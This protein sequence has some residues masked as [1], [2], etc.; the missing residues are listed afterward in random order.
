M[1]KNFSYDQLQNK[2]EAL[3]EELA[4]LRKSRQTLVK[5]E[6]LLRNIADNSLAG[7][8]VVQN[9]K[10][11][12][13]NTNATSF[14]GYGPEELIGRS[15]Y[16]IVHTEDRAMVKQNARAMLRGERKS[17]YEFRIIS[18]NKRVRWILEMVTAI[19]YKG[20]PAILGNSMDITERKLK[21][22]VLRESEQRLTDIIAFLPDATLAIDNEG[23]VIIWNR[24]IEEMT[25]IPAKNML[26]KGNYEYALPFYRERRPLLVD[27]LLKPDTQSEMKYSIV[28]KQQDLLIAEAESPFLRGKCAFLWGKASPLYDSRGNILGAIET[29]RDITDRKLAEEGLRESERRLSD[30]I[31]F[32]PD[33][34]LVIDRK[35]KVIAWNRAIEEMTGVTAQDMLGKENHEYAVPFYGKPRPIMI[36]LVLKSNSKVERGYCSII[37]RQ[38]DLLIVETW[39]PALKGKRAFLWG[40]ASPLYDSKRNVVGAIES[41]RDITERKQDEE[42]LKNREQELQAKKNQLE[43]LNAALRVLLK[44]REE[45]KNDL[46]EKILANVKKLIIPYLDKL[47]MESKGLKTMAYIGVLESNLKDIIAPFAHRISSKYVSLTNREVQIAGLIKEG[48][49]TKEIAEMLNISESAI[50]IHRYNIRRKLGLTKKHNLQTYLSSLA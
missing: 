8:Y 19:T 24:A 33:A 29:I 37:E 2:L 42:A 17:P 1:S 6:Q 18:K 9:G 38:Q 48:R 25:G 15:S 49:I 35:G 34:T 50:N 13:L 26:G 22:D 32:L 41:I 4:D 27:L 46:E 10:F 16:Y 11:R 3:E 30:I 45:D 5:G 39:V 14:A 36:D 44:Q 12:F 40:K 28:M 21:D 43:D 7:I 31:D 20:E 47:R 23:K